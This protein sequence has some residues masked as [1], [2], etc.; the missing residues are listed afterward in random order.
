MVLRVRVQGLPNVLKLLKRADK[1]TDGA[2]LLDQA[3]AV[4]LN[5]TRTRFLAEVSPDQI[6]WEKSK[7][8]IGKTL[9]DT[10]ALFQSLEG[11]REGNQ[12]IVRVNPSAVNPKTGESVEDYAVKHQEGLDGFPTRQ[13]LGV[14]NEDAQ[15]IEQLIARTLQRALDRGL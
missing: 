1:E 4:L 9:F 15:V 7:K 2:E 8:A 5:R 6:P 11:V 10:G 12:G 3:T 14:S 13:F